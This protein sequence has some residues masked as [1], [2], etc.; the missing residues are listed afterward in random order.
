M[1]WMRVRRMWALYVAN[2]REFLR[3]RLTLFLVLL[4]PVAL[5]VFFGL[6][7]GGDEAFTLQVGLVDEDGGAIGAQVRSDLDGHDMLGLRCGAR[8]ELLDAL[9]KGE[10]SVVLVLPAGASAALAA[11]T[12]VEVEVLYDPARSISGATGLGFVRT[13]L[14]EV[15]L[16]LSGASHLLLME[17]R[18]VQTR[19]LRA[20]DLHLSGFLGI[21]MIWKGLF[22]TTAKVGQL[23]QK[24]VLRRL[25]LTPLAPITFLA[26]H[27]AWS[28][29]VGLL[30]AALFLLV[31]RLAFGVQ[32]AG[33]WGLLLGAV[34]LGS[35]V[36]TALGYCLTS[37]SSS[38]EATAVAIQILNFPM[39]MLSG[40]LFSID[41]L[42][43]YFRPLAA[44]LPLTYLNDALRQLMV[45]A[46][47][48]HAL[49]VDFAVL[50]G[51]LV[52]LLGLTVRFW[53]WE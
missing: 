10:V 30:Q 46:A 48:L 40:S 17:E 52:A 43:A 14:G 42:P 26:A 32:V 9:H 45:G 31:G 47:P 19:P 12:P 16:A 23:R 24:Q 38:A 50:G 7:F 21:S 33:S 20:I 8:Q 35:L 25:C 6:I 3:D 11:G 41:A 4:L 34:V 39:M 18:S 29:T 2:A 36:S 5:A 1:Q 49:W 37:L 28:L 51:W 13:Y 22:S 44:I 15:N 27:V 53:R